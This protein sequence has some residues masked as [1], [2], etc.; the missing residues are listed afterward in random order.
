[1]DDRKRKEFA[2]LLVSFETEK[3][4]DRSL[5]RGRAIERNRY[6][7]RFG[8][9][10]RTVIVPTL[11]EFMMDLDKK[12]H[13]TRLRDQSAEKVRLDVQ[14][15]AKTA[16]RGA[17]EFALHRTEAGKVRVEYGWG[18]DGRQEIYPLDQIAEAFVAE[19]VL[20]MLK[21]LL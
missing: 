15:S 4:Q 12:G 6:A 19:R 17:I 14:I 5:E 8:E 2:E 21:G 18:F 11:R 20:E 10:K 16:R 9:L 1:V 3:E 13:M 7:L